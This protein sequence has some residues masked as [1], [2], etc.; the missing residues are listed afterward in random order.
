MIM[1]HLLA[2]IAVAAMASAAEL[3]DSSEVARNWAENTTVLP[4]LTGNLSLRAQIAPP[5]LA[6][7]P[8]S[9]SDCW[10]AATPSRTYRNGDVLEVPSGQ[11]AGKG[12]LLMAPD[13]DKLPPGAKPWKY[14]GQTFWLIPIAANEAK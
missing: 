14:R 7:W 12:F 13:G 6:S 5:P 9:I 1:P 10:P 8:I 2:S 3:K 4:Q 11:D